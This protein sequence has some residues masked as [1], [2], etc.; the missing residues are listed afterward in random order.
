MQNNLMLV[1]VHDIFIILKSQFYILLHVMFINSN[2]IIIIYSKKIT[3]IFLHEFTCMHLFFNS[4]SWKE[5]KTRIDSPSVVVIVTSREN[6]IVILMADLEAF[7]T[8]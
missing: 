2:I 7:V 6:I 5:G 4:V 8:H 1:K 3:R